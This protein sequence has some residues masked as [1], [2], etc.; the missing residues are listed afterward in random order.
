MDNKE[1]N[2]VILESACELLGQMNFEVDDALRKLRELRRRI[3][4]ARTF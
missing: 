1:R 4:F 3:L 2:Q